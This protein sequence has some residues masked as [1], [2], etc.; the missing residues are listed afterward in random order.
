MLSFDRRTFFLLLFI[1]I[2]LPELSAGTV[3]VAPHLAPDCH[4]DSLRFQTSLKC[5]DRFPSRLYIRALLDRIDRNQIHMPVLIL[6]QR[7]QLARLVQ[8]VVDS[9]TRLYSNV[10]RRPVFSK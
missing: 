10:M 8:I 1:H 3:Y 9:R 7:R 2:A 4:I 5:F 6:N